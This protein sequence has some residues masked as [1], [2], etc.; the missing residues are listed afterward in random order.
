MATTS[1]K[2]GT[3]LWGSSSGINGTEMAAVLGWS[4]TQRAIVH[5]YHASSGSGTEGS[6]YKDR[7]TGPQDWSATVRCKYDAATNV[8]PVIGET[9]EVTLHVD[10]GVALSGQHD[11][12]YAQ[13]V[14]ENV[15]LEVDVD[16]GKVVAFV[17][18]ISGSG[19]L[20]FD[21]STPP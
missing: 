4:M 15:E 13:C 18:S 17:L 5:A 10:D 14:A 8:V 19:A 2:G 3:V 6:G 9:V 12:Y 11:R 1:G 21:Q 20:T 7:L 16:D